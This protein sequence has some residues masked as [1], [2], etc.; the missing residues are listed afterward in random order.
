MNPAIILLIE[1]LTPEAIAFVEFVIQ[2]VHKQQ[3]GTVTPMPFPDA[4]KE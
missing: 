3:T 2:F 4:P 1:E